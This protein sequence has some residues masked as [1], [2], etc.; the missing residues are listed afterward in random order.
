MAGCDTGAAG[1]DETS[2]GGGSSTKAAAAVHVSRRCRPNRL[3]GWEFRCSS[4]CHSAHRLGDSAFLEPEQAVKCPDC[5]QLIQTGWTTHAL[6]CGSRD[7]E[8]L[9]QSTK[10]H[11]AM[12]S[13]IATCAAQGARHG[14]GP[15]GDGLQSLGCVL[16]VP[17]RPRIPAA[18]SDPPNQLQVEP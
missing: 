16:L 17:F 9:T 13:E 7:S 14:Q 5:R 8:A 10:L 15:R 11:V 6:T 12:D 18:G 3:T 1:R 4:S 2:G